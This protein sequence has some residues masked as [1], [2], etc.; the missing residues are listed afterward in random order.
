MLIIQNFYVHIAFTILY[1]KHFE[2]SLELY[3]IILRSEWN[4]IVVSC[5]I[6][7]KT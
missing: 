6:I 7:A 3:A 1:I 4:Y 5:N 2:I